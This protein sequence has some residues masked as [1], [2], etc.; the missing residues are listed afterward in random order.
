MPDL[1][2]KPIPPHGGDRKPPLRDFVDYEIEGELGRGGMGVVY[3]ARQKELNRR[4]ALKMLTG[5]Y[6]ADELH[7]FIEEAETAAGLKHTN[8]APVYE[9]GEHEGAP[10]FS[11][12]YVEGGSLSDLLRREV[13]PPRRSAELMMQVARALHYAHQNGVV[14]RDMKPANVLLDPDGVPKIADFGIAKRMDDDSKLT[15]SGAVIG[16]PTYMAPEQAKGNSRHVGPAADIYSL[17]TILYEMLAGRPPFLP[18]D[19]EVAVTVR[20]LTEDPVSPAWHQP[21]I[22]RDLETICM[23]CLEKEPRKRYLNAGEFAEDLRRFL[24][25]E[26]IRAKPP[27]TI[28]SSI[29]WVR[30]HPWKFVGM[31]AG[32]IVVVAAVVGLVRWE[33]YARPRLEYATR[34]D[35]VNG[36][37]EPISKV[38]QENATHSGAYI[39]LTRRG[40]RGPI[41]KAEVLNARGYPAVLRRIGATELIPIYIEGITGAQQYGESQPETS[42]VEFRFSDGKA[43]EAIARDRNGFVTWRTIYE[44][45]P[46]ENSQTYGARF[47]NQRGFD[48][49][50]RAGASRLEFERD[51]HGRDIKITFF[52]T[53]GRPAANGEGVYGYKLE[54][55]AAGRIV[56]IISLAKD[57]RPGPNRAGLVG[58]AVTWNSAGYASRLDVRDANGQPVEWSGISALTNEY[59]S[60]G[61]LIRVTNIGPDGQPQRSATAEWSV[62]ELKRNE[63]GELT[64]R[65]FLKAQPDGSLK[66]IRQTIIAYDEFGHPADMQQIGPN[67]WRSAW[68]RDANGNVNEEKFLDPQG[69]PVAGEN[70]YAIRRFSYTSGPQGK[71]IE[72]TYFDAAGGKTF[73]KAGNH[74]LIDEFNA[75]GQLFRQTTEDHDP[76]RYKYYRFVSEPEFDSEGRLVHSTYRFENQNGQLATEAGLPYTSI[77][78]FYDEEGRPL[79][80]WK[81]GVDPKI[82]GGSVLQIETQYHSNGNPKLRVRQ[83]CDENRKPLAVI[84]NGT[85]SRLEEQ[86]S[87]DEQRERIYETGFDEKLVGFNTRETKFSN[88]TLQSVTHKRGDGSTVPSVRVIITGITP[89]AE[90]P[91]SVELQAGDQLLSANGKPVATA[92]AWVF[93]GFSGG[94]VEVLRNGQRVRID[95]FVA[96][97][98]GMILE[99]RALENSAR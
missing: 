53:A 28:G 49:A 59:D 15:R 10:Y 29:K 94:W 52:N 63:R 54:R 32:V 41:I 36:A 8:I 51:A 88:G 91:K 3:L 77:E 83:V 78:D 9:V 31:A 7:R 74:R 30:R 50:S 70:G 39:R 46:D 72:E 20:V 87:A 37:L 4:V 44:E 25:D 95:G 45:R 5:H 47:V 14:H 58:Y 68:R 96:G 71:R 26:S 12:E 64:Q 89:P 19:S 42:S 17:G 80:E 97:P 90:Q 48:A 21:E 82:V 24:D 23:K 57:G 81:I 16:T 40:R 38:S 65:T 66:Q 61:N 55:D 22:P 84:S 6:G 33:L 60:F 73:N 79:T 99:D 93:S 27:G 18:E 34:V 98:L 86:F 69:Q 56:Q 1:T 62:S 11:M 67:S 43:K 13:P 92:Y 35:W 75:N 2:I 85:A 76:A